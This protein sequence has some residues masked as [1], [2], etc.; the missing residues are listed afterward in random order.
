MFCV[1]H[2]TKLLLILIIYW[3]GLFPEQMIHRCGHFIAMVLKCMNDQE[4]KKKEEFYWRKTCVLSPTTVDWMSCYLNNVLQTHTFWS[5]TCSGFLAKL[6]QV[7][8]QLNLDPKY[9]DAG[10]LFDCVTMQ[11]VHKRN[12]L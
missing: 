6:R 8:I 3:L 1:I 4:K 9:V 10:Q 2:D 7:V 11:I 12:K 5:N